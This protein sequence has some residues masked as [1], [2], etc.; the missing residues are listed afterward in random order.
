MRELYTENIIHQTDRFFAKQKLLQEVFSHL[1]TEN[2][3]SHNFMKYNYKTWNS[4]QG[5]KTAVIQV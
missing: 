3:C 4:R 5:S 2:Q 1:T